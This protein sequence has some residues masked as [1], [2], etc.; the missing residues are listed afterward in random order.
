MAERL[1]IATWHADLSRDGPGLM[2]AE[3]ERGSPAVTAA[4]EAIRA[5]D[6][7]VVL[8]TGIDHDTRLVALGVLAGRLAVAGIA[9][10]YRFALPPNAG[11]PTGMDL[12][13]DGRRG[14]PRDAMG[15]G[16]FQGQGGMV[17][18]SRL[19]VLAYEDYTGFLWADLP[20]ALLPPGMSGAER[21]MQRLSS[22][23]HWWVELGLPSGGRLG[24]LAFAATPPVFDGPE[25]RNG[26]RNHDE[27]AF[28]LRLMD[29]ALPVAPPAPPFVLLGDANLDPEDGDGRPE[30][31]QA[32]LAD[33]R[34]QDPQPRRAPGHDDPGQKGDPALDTALYPEGPG[35]LRVDYV[36]PSAGLKV[37]GSGLEAPVPGARHLPVWV[38]LDLP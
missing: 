13:G 1:R 37:L 24:L 4:I 15:F 9:Y 10:P 38:D 36:L 8:L 14:G 29:G 6:A 35:G 34:L 28:W 23:N 3:I 26:R 20:G 2:L 27:T 5:L 32:L 21:A 31:L 18:L 30:A 19:P 25:D 7:D 12:D 22:V 16:R 33:P 11:V 17:L